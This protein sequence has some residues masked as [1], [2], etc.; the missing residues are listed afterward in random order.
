MERGKKNENLE[1]C[2]HSVLSPIPNTI[3][4]KQLGTEYLDTVKQQHSK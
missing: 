4:T 2:K 3:K 1:H